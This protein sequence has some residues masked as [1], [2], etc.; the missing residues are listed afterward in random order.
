M[1]ASACRTCHNRNYEGLFYDWMKSLNNRESQADI[2]L[3]R[4]RNE[5]ASDAEI[6]EKKIDHAKHVGFHNIPLSVTLWDEIL[7]EKPGESTQNEPD[8][9]K[10]LGE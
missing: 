8:S 10:T 4:L 1:Y 2:L 3:R 5:N 6:L 7:G 9:L